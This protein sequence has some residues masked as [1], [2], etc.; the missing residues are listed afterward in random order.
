V[1]GRCA[2]LQHAGRRV[3]R[4]PAHRR[5][6]TRADPARA[7]VKGDLPPGPPMTNTEPLARRH[8]LHQDV[9]AHHRGPPPGVLRSR[10]PHPP[11]NFLGPKALEDLPGAALLASGRG[12]ASVGA[13]RTR[14]GRK[15]GVGVDPSLV[16]PTKDSGRRLVQSAKK[17]EKKLRD[18]VQVTVKT[19]AN[20][21]ELS[22][23]LR[24]IKGRLHGALEL[25]EQNADLSLREL[26]SQIA[27]GPQALEQRYGIS[28]AQAAL[29][30]SSSH[31]RATHPPP[32]S[33]TGS[34]ASPAARIHR[35]R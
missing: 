4:A 20:R 26:A 3:A 6:T 33:R 32:K 30:A 8:V 11:H 27:A 21:A 23:L 31:D 22:T 9:R 15:L 35:W 1:G 17:V 19:A 7:T 24:G 29:L 16:E 12:A 28:H 10:V 5:R 18:R 2:R 25:L 34:K 13:G 14:C